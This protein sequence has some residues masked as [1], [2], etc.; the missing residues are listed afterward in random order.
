MAE[1]FLKCEDTAAAHKM[2]AMVFG[3][4][5]A[6]HMKDGKVR[7]SDSM[8]SGV[9]E[10]RP[11]EIRLKPRV[12]TYR[13]K[14]ERNAILVKME[15]I[16]VIPEEFMG[17]T[18]FTSKEEYAFLCILLMF[19]EEKDT[20]EQF[21]LS[22]LTE[23]I[24]ANM[25]GEAVEWTLYTNRRRLIRVL[26]Y[27]VSQGILKITDGSDDVF[28]EDVSGEVLYENTGASRYFMRSFSH[29]IME[30][31][32]PEDFSESEW[33]H[34]DE[35]RG[36]ARRHRVYKRRLFAP[37]M[38]Y[39]DGSPG[40]F[41]YLKYYR[42]RLIDDLEK[43]FDCQIHIYRGSAYLMSGE[44]CRIGKVFPENKVISDI[45]L[46]VSGE[47]RERII[48]G[49]WKLSA[50]ETCMADRIVFEHMLSDVREKYG[51]GFTKNYRE[52]TEQDFI[53]NVLEELKIWMFIREK[54][55]SQQVVIYPM[56]GKMCGKYPKDYLEVQKNE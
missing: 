44:E 45:C 39:G 36:M 49:E 31:T 18:E 54:K 53:R 50:D 3:M 48:K 19:L 42:N 23:Y 37:A 9:Y 12:R 27:S 25:P 16:P 17:I 8:N 38:Y 56:T 14:A 30:Y 43:T 47:V 2:S 55:E 35:D 11:D 20:Q 15:K 52:M 28:M 32:S 10:E 22:Q 41:E 5:S 29:D 4:E 7:E 21:I 26:R 33:F 40:D 6:W 51:S 24:A 1:L 34:V 13:E 46:L